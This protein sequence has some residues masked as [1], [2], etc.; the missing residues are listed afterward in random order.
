MPQMTLAFPDKLVICVLICR[1]DHLLRLGSNSQVNSTFFLLL[2]W[3]GHSKGLVRGMA[4]G[5]LPS[6]FGEANVVRVSRASG[7]PG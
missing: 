6:V 2:L 7:A 5:L 3:C 1:S 4:R